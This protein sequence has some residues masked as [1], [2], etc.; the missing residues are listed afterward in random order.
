MANFLSTL[1]SVDCIFRTAEKPK[2][3]MSPGS[4]GT[5]PPAKL[6]DIQASLAKAPP[7]GYLLDH[8]QQKSITHSSSTAGRDN[9]LG[10][11]V[12]SDV[13]TTKGSRLVDEDEHAECITINLGGGI[14]ALSGDTTIAT[15]T[16]LQLEQEPTIINSPFLNE[17]SHSSRLQSQADKTCVGPQLALA[18]CPIGHDSGETTEVTSAVEV[19]P[20]STT[21]TEHDDTQL[22]PSFLS[23][24]AKHKDHIKSTEVMSSSDATG[25]RDNQMAAQEPSTF[26]DLGT[27]IESRASSAEGVSESILGRQGALLGPQDSAQQLPV[28]NQPF[29]GTLDDLDDTA[30]NDLLTRLTSGNESGDESNPPKGPQPVFRRSGSASEVFKSRGRSSESSAAVPE[31]IVTRSD[32]LQKENCQALN[33]TSRVSSLQHG[34][35]SVSPLSSSNDLQEDRASTPGKTK[36]LLPSDSMTAPVPQDTQSTPVHRRPGLE[37]QGHQFSGELDSAVASK[38]NQS[39]TTSSQ[40]EKAPPL[41]PLKVPLGDATK[42]GKY[43][44]AQILKDQARRKRE[45]AAKKKL[46]E[47]GI[48]ARPKG[49]LVHSEISSKTPSPSSWTNPNHLALNEKPRVSIAVPNAQSDCLENVTS[50]LDIHDSNHNSPTRPLSGVVSAISKTAGPNSPRKD[51]GPW[52]EPQT[53][54]VQSLVDSSVRERVETAKDPVTAFVDTIETPLPSTEPEFGANGTHALGRDAHRLT[55]DEDLFVSEEEQTSKECSEIV[56]QWSQTQPEERNSPTISVPLDVAEAYL[57]HSLNTE[58]NQKKRTAL[59]SLEDSSMLNPSSKKA[60]HDAYHTQHLGATL[61][62]GRGSTPTRKVCASIPSA[63]FQNG[64]PAPR[65]RLTSEER[66][67]RKRISRI[68]HAQK[69]KAEKEERERLISQTRGSSFDPDQLPSAN[70][71]RPRSPTVYIFDPHANGPKWT[72]QPLGFA[73]LNQSTAS[74][75]EPNDYEMTTNRPT[76]RKPRDRTKENAQRREKRQQEKELQ[77]SRN[78]QSSKADLHC[79]DRPIIDASELK[80]KVSKVSNMLQQAAHNARSEKARIAF[81]RQDDER[82]AKI[83]AALQRFQ[84]TKPEQVGT[85][86]GSGTSDAHAGHDDDSCTLLDDFR[87]D[88]TSDEDETEEQTNARRKQ[89]QNTLKRMVRPNQE[90]VKSFYN[91]K[92]TTGGKQPVGPTNHHQ[93]DRSNGTD[94]S[95]IF[96]DPNEDE[97]FFVPALNPTTAQKRLPNYQVQLELAAYAG[98]LNLKD[99]EPHVDQTDARDTDGEEEGEEEAEDMVF[100][101]TVTRTEFHSDKTE[102]EPLKTTSPTFYTKDEANA[103]ALHNVF[104]L[105]HDCPLG[106]EGKMMM[107]WDATGMHEYSFTSGPLTVQATVS[108]QIVRNA[109]LPSPAARVPRETYVIYKKS[110]TLGPDR[111]KNISQEVLGIHGLLDKANRDAGAAWLRFAFQRIMAEPGIRE[112]REIELENEVRER[113]GGLEARNACFGELWQEGEEWVEIWVEGR[114]VRGPRN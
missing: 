44:A 79:K 40:C 88:V 85:S 24:H 19:L 90:P 30:L 20:G 12:P 21:I 53:E 52:L 94:N 36:R 39:D 3:Q 107:E 101:Y 78:L 56:G 104:S 35:P 27:I 2:S 49:D 65:K 99:E 34:K 68:K 9:Q 10:A 23:D 25:T 26:T 93:H 32:K 108:R 37:S 28:T 82:R 45:R 86:C 66:R 17:P 114:R 63:I 98:Q 100:Q 51:A 73:A 62:R 22:P 14:E 106:H 18:D 33:K 110:V 103:Y 69:K 92:P 5:P 57:A 15:P 4:L 41:P 11:T 83:R 7:T 59:V 84:K 89:R 96:A 105:Q 80:I 74:S 55:D 87:S 95:P 6:G 29:T 102:N 43:L 67:E 113:L 48:E 97:S 31:R 58:N 64:P 81:V 42:R 60:K 111:G 72:G 109:P 54:T 46:A 16:P 13:V 76:A 91:E 50:S 38:V 61:Q 47:N 77:D 75:V 8:V 1:K 70:V 112:L 71:V